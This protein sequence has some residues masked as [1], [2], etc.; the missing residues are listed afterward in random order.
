MSNFLTILRQIGPV[1]LAVVCF[2][3]VTTIGLISLMVT[4]V[5]QPQTALLYGD[6]DPSDSSKI[7]SQLDTMGIP[8]ELGQNGQQIFVPT[9]KVNKLRL[10]MAE[11]GLPGSGSVGYELFDKMDT[12][13]TTSFVQ[14][15]QHVRALEGE[16]SRTI[17]TISSIKL[18]RVHLVLP[19]RQLFERETDL[20]SASVILQMKG[21]GRLSSGQVAAI[22]HLIAASISRLTPDHVAIIDQHGTLLARGKSGG[23]ATLQGG[24]HLDEMRQNYEQRL[25]ES[26]E[27]LLQKTIGIGK[28]R[29]E[30]TA[31]MDYDRIVENAEI[32]DPEGQVVRS[33]QT[34][35]E[36]EGSGS[37][38]GVASVSNSLPGGA[39]NTG[40]SSGNQSRTEETVN[41]EISKT[42]RN[43][44]KE[45]GTIKRI[46]VAVLVDGTYTAA[47][48]GKKTY[49]PR[50]EQTMDQITK[51]V[52]SAVGYNADRGDVVEVTNMPFV[53][54]E[55]TMTADETDT[56]PG[57]F[58]FNKNDIVKLLEILGL[59][60]GIV[61][62]VFI[63]LKPSIKKL[64]NTQ[65]AALA[66]M[67]PALAGP[68]ASLP[69]SEVIEPKSEIVDAHQEEMINIQQIEGKVKASSVK[70][71]SEIVERHPEEV[72]NVIRNW[73]YQKE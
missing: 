13:G 2:I 63:G 41:F 7:I 68:Q 40:G 57:L 21:G 25:A 36:K 24:K 60:I 69:A 35:D 59:V 1:R 33:N 55:D 73:V 72:A 23:D 43:H 49:A 66:G 6:L 53:D 67:T 14:N 64:I 52:Q 34:V 70:K 37:A 27:S 20:P 46:S 44:T 65:G 38:S 48:D 15:I 32:F 62:L 58:S 42:I 30:V 3:L 16:L 12:L 19:Q 4:R 22:Q 54:I 26:V 47:A 51:L 11:D 61:V 71:V 10:L 28:V 18:A 39:A 45:A 29:A 17:Q 9:D 31:D 8:Y 50:D 56:A 5:T